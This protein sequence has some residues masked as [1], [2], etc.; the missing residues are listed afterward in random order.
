MTTPKHILVIDVGGTNI[1]ILATGIDERIKIPSGEEMTPKKMV[2]EV[3]EAAA[4]WKYEAVSIAYPGAI[5]DGEII[6]EPHNL[7]PGW[8]DF[9]FAKAFGCPVRILNDAATQAL[10][11]YEGGTML[12]L[13]L[14]T[15]LGA[16]L[17]KKGIVIP[18]EIAHLP[19]REERSYE[20]YWGKDARKR[21]GE[22]KWQKHVKKIIKLLSDAFVVEEVVLGGGNAD[23]VDDLPKNVRLG[24]NANAFKGGFR[25]WNRD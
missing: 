15:G 10:G 22:E 17:V 8:V 3:Q 21:L 7:G 12:F 4:D 6:K 16:A 13:G 25:L 11:S 5:I 18:L 24:S 20:E 2:K 9:D 19:Y 1:K 14:G 23:E